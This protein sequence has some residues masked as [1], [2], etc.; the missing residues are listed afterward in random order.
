MSIF[1]RKAAPM[2]Y[3]P[4]YVSF[5]YYNEKYGT[6]PTI[7]GQKFVFNIKSFMYILLSAL[8]PHHCSL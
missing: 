1:L 4:E 3:E 8:S 5:K 7:V 2:C 6:A